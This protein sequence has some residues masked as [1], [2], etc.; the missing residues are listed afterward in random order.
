M[1]RAYVKVKVIN[2]VQTYTCNFH[3]VYIIIF[4]DCIMSALY[5]MHVYYG[6]RY[7]LTKVHQYFKNMKRYAFSSLKSL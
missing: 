6:K 7:L 1:H 2:G 3:F 4:N 5:L